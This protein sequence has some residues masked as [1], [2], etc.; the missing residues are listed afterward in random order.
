MSFYH[1]WMGN[2]VH[3]TII[4][5]PTCRR[6]SLLG[7]EGSYPRAADIMSH[8]DGLNWHTKGFKDLYNEDLIWGAVMVYSKHLGLCM[9][10]KVDDWPLLHRLIWIRINDTKGWYHL[11]L[12]M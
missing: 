12:S 10:K 3:Q 5:A 7:E 9:V 11:S 4:L 8:V 6:F 2:M 1:P